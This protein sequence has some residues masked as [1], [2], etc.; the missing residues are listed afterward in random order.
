MLENVRVGRRAKKRT[1]TPR[2][3]GPGP[4]QPKRAPH[5]RSQERSVFREGTSQKLLLLRTPAV[6]STY[7]I[8]ALWLASRKSFGVSPAG[9]EKPGLSRPL[10][11]HFA[12]HHHQTRPS[13]SL[14]KFG[15]GALFPCVGLGPL[16][17]HPLLRTVG[18][19]IRPCAPETPLWCQSQAE[20][21][22][23]RGVRQ[24]PP[25]VGGCRL[26]LW[27]ADPSP[28][29]ARLLSLSPRPLCTRAVPRSRY[30]LRPKN[31]ACGQT[32][33]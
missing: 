30:P 33:G 21:R 13:V 9:G 18:A 11:A 1:A 26:W 28:G 19:E 5:R 32:A 23:T 25:P 31:P 22:G 12:S 7:L 15:I 29:R 6:S 2:T 17:L 20:R 24:P 10:T 14:G 8:H 16:Q 3:S 4:R 27:V